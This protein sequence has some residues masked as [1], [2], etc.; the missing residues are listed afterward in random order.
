MSRRCDTEGCTKWRSIGFFCKEHQPG[1]APVGV[2]ASSGHAG[3]AGTALGV[4]M[5]V[6]STPSSAAT[7]AHQ[8]KLRNILKVAKSLLYY[9]IC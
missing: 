7:E 8:T 4:V 2:V 9:H 6:T 3:V 1:D 5:L